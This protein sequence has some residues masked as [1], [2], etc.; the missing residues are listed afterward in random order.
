MSTISAVY[1]QFTPMVIPETQTANVLLEVKVEGGPPTAVKLELLSTGMEVT[2]RDDGSGGDKVAGDGIY[3]VTLKAAD[4]LYNFTPDDVNRNFIGYLRLYL[5]TQL[6]EQSNISAD[7]LTANIPP[8]QITPVSAEVQYTKHLVNIVAPGF[9][10]LL[11]TTHVTNKF[12]NYFRDEYDF[13]NVISAIGFF[14]NRHF[15]GVRSNVQGIGTQLFDHGI[16]YGSGV[17][18]LGCI[19]F[20]LPTYFDGASSNY[21]HELGHHWINFLPVP[22]LDY[23]I[24]HWPLS[25]LASDIMGRGEGKNTEGVEFNYDLVPVGNDFQL[26]ANNNPKAFS[27]LSLYLMGLLLPSQVGTH[28]VFNDQIQA[29]VGNI[30]HGPVTYVSVADIIKKLGARVPD[31]SQAQKKFRVATIIVSKDGLLSDDAMRLYDYFSARAEETHLVPFSIGRVKGQTKPFYLTTQGLGR[32]DTRIKRHILI[33]AS[34]DGGVWWFPQ[35]GP[36]DSTAKHQG[37][38]LAEYLRSLGHRVV[39]L[40]RPTVITSKLLADYDIIIRTAGFGK[41]T[42]AEIAAYLDY[43]QNDGNLLL[44]A[45]HGPADE[46][47]LSLGLRFAGVTRGENMLTGYAAHPLTQ[48]LGPL[49]Y[50]VGSA[51]LSFPITAQILGWLSGRSY[52]DLNDNNV[53]DAGEPSAPPV[54]GVMNYGTGR[55]VFC[56]DTNL[57]EAVPQP[58]VDNVMQWFADP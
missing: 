40:P 23:A 27:D 32:L 25:D 41:Y 46:L 2:L 33:D 34:R 38:A 5:G 49:F 31:A 30:L 24:P 1:Y 52:L 12:Y 11:D 19:L 54:L 44:L 47:A 8:V 29:P 17:R 4:V 22:P 36:F 43:V 55:I 45:E 18:L 26:V 9:F 15:E 10:P 57:W 53:Q 6:K 7:I 3:T 37:K 48:G 16:T 21:Q 39:E 56:G 42:K 35:V 13:L 51:L 28:F 58:L 20:P 14:Q 50:N